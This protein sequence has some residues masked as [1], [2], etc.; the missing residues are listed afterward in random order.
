[1]SVAR[2]ARSPSRLVEKLK[3][4]MARGLAERANEVGAEQ[5]LCDLMGGRIPA[6]EIPQLAAEVRRNHQ[7]SRAEVEEHPVGAMLMKAC[8]QAD[9]A[10]RYA[11]V[12]VFASFHGDVERRFELLLG[13]LGKLDQA[14]Q[15]R[16][17]GRAR[18]AFEAAAAVSESQY[19]PFVQNIW[20]LARYRKGRA[21]GTAPTYGALFQGIPSEWNASL[22]GPQAV[23]VRNAYAH[24]LFRYLP[25]ER[26]I[27]YWDRRGSKDRASAREL[28]EFTHHM[29]HVSGTLNQQVM[30]YWIAI[31]Y[32]ELGLVEAALRVGTL[33][34]E[35]SPDLI[36]ELNVE[37]EARMKAGFADI[38][39]CHEKAA[40]AK[41]RRSTREGK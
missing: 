3:S 14:S 21:P 1:M 6:E 7:L 29:L 33:I 18:L 24:G 11:P 35:G 16:G 22:M 39:R 30:S 40:N 12:V 34:R 36:Q 17:E 26:A 32:M 5:V 27:E 28:L 25:Q 15:R 38:A 20:R 9:A 37:M 10:V 23:K 4:D 41:A 13:A 31:P 19:Q 2:M 8:D